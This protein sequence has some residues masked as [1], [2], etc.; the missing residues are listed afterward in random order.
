MNVYT[1]NSTM[2]CANKKDETM[3]SYSPKGPVET[4]INT[5]TIWPQTNNKIMTDGRSL[6]K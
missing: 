5:Y 2:F 6:S 3:K 4:I 1:R